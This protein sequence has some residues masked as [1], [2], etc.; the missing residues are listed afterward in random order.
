MSPLQDNFFKSSLIQVPKQF[1]FSGD[2]YYFVKDL[3]L[4]YILEEL[5]SN[6]LIE[7]VNTNDD[8]ASIKNTPIIIH[9]RNELKKWCDNNIDSNSHFKFKQLLIGEKY[10]VSIV[11][12]DGQPCYFAISKD[13]R[14]D[15]KFLEGSPISSI[16]L[17]DE[18]PEFQKIIEFSVTTLK[19]LTYGYPPNGVLNL[20]LLLQEESNKFLITEI[21]TGSPGTHK[22]KMFEQ[23][24]G[25]KLNELHL[26]LQIGGSPAIEPK[27]DFKYSAYSIH[28]KP[29]G[30]VTR[31]EKPDLGC[32]AQINW[33]IS[34]GE[35]YFGA[36]N[37]D[38]IAIA[39][40]LSH[41]DYS[42]LEETLKIANSSNFYE[43][44]KIFDFP[45]QIS[46]L[47]KV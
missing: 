42:T 27:K 18:D 15:D 37:I 35:R 14:F 21:I 25:I 20:N 8:S 34:P 33:H 28:P 22:S 46:S 32:D 30:L 38:D 13:Y 39:I 36:K 44:E 31:I 40:L 17:R 29:H 16:V 6:I 5:G 11:I 41:H 9:G 45:A 24:Q 47:A 10:S 3:Y 43:T 4:Q 19:Q 7:T 26:Q 1:T 12:K 23:Y 2:K